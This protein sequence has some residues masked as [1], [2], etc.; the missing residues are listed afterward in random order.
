MSE[1]SDKL[2]ALFQAMDDTPVVR[3]TYKRGP[4]NYT[5]SKRETLDEI[6]LLLPHSNTWVDVFGGSGIV[7]LARKPSKLEVFNDR[8]SGICDFFR[9]CQAEPD[10]LVAIIELMPHSRE[11]FIRAKDE[12]SKDEDYV[13][14]GARW[15]YLVQS[16]FAGRGQYFGRVV[17]GNNSILAKL[18]KN[19]EL[20]PWVH[21]RFKQVT[22][23]N[24]DWEQCFDDYDG[25]DVV[26]YCDPPYVGSNI[27]EHSM[28]L[29]E[30]KRLCEKI[31]ASK[32]FVA[33]SGFDN[34]VYNSFP[35]DGKHAFDI[36]NIVSTVE[37]GAGDRNKSRI[38]CLWIKEASA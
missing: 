21:R 33:L 35:W 31:F 36:K 11:L 37:Y 28:S 17:K 15:Y 4:L 38:E 20:F 26:F 1:E 14:R 8:H 9:A 18:Y 24:L 22:V 34:D 10:R 32:G 25:Y 2:L 30:H 3:E 29:D 7:T 6:L 12:V 5:G 13:T 23:E 27:Y 19:L 16:S